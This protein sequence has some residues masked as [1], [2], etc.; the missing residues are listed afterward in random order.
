[1]SDISELSVSVSN[2][3]SDEDLL[4]DE[5]EDENVIGN[6][7]VD[8][9]PY[10]DDPLASSSDEEHADNDDELDDDGISREVLLRRFEGRD[11]V[12]SW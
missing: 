10:Q 3:G 9:D 7:E 4:S 11:P 6:V 12:N 5:E 1:M 2:P 8:F